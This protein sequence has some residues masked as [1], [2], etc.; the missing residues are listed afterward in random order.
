MEKDILKNMKVAIVFSPSKIDE[1]LSILFP[2]EFVIG[3][4]SNDGKYIIDYKNG[5]RFK[6]A[7]SAILD[8]EQLFSFYE[9]HSLEE[10]IKKYDCKSL[11][12]ILIEL[13]KHYADNVYFF[14]NNEHVIEKMEHKL[15]EEKYQL[16]VDT[17]MEN[18]EYSL[19][20]E[21]MED[22]FINQPESQKENTD[23]NNNASDVK[24]TKVVFPNIK[25]VYNYIKETVIAQDEAIRK[26]LTA[27]YKNAIISNPRFKSN[28]L[29][30]GNTGMGKTEILRQIES[31]IKLPVF[32]ADMNNFTQAGFKGSNVVDMLR[33]LYIE[34]NYDLQLA[35]K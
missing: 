10:L 18:F 28:V 13:S 20:E 16:A 19:D 24:K 12:D 1:N 6:E 26:I 3:E 30:Y 14:N 2:I 8:K 23:E 22:D 21:I 34:A 31:I 5:Q 29:L 17:I 25:E 32:I 35:Q 15:F 27:I 7:T 11:K 4:V 9:P 33:S